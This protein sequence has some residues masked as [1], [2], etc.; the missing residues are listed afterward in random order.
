[1]TPEERA[2]SKTKRAEK[3]HTSWFARRK[4]GES[5]KK[6]TLKVEKNVKRKVLKLGK[7]AR[8]HAS[9]AFE[10]DKVTR[11]DMEITREVVEGVQGSPEEPVT[12]KPVPFAEPA[13]PETF[14][15]V[16]C[17]ANVP[18]GAENCPSCE[19]HYV[20]NVSEEQ[21]RDLEDAEREVREETLPD[22]GGMIGRK[23]VPCVHFNAEEGTVSYLQ[24]DHET[25]NVSA[26]CSNCDTEIE[27]DVDRCPICGTKLTKMENGLVGL[28]DGIE[29]DNDDSPEM[30][31]PFCGEHVVLA[32]GICP[33]CKETVQPAGNGG[34]SEKVD[35]VIHMD[36]V[37]FLHLDVSTGEVNY[38]QR[39]ARNRGFEQVTVKLDGIGH[40]GFDKDWKSLSRV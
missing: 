31:C 18:V 34:Q 22:A 32:D 7:M 19:C 3:A 25:A 37:V 40:G 28:V 11:K 30:E 23:E 4:D 24:D 29:F 12:D 9:E 6:V 2:G 38:L 36:N 39:L 20:S 13:A 1:M 21:L 27:F 8:H 5:P 16:Q 35:P 10:P 33:S 26:V 17:G 14:I 15:C